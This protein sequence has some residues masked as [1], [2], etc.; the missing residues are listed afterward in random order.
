MEIAGRTAYK[1]DEKGGSVVCFWETTAKNEFQSK[2]QG[3]PIFDLVIMGE[4]R[5]PGAKMSVFDFEIER[6]ITDGPIKQRVNERS[7]LWVDVL[8]IQLDAWRKQKTDQTLSGTPLESWPRLGV[9]EI[10]SLR[11][12]GI[13]S[14][15]QLSEVPDS[16]LEVLGMNGRVLRDQAKAHIELAKNNAPMEALVAKNNE[17]ELALA[18]LKEQFEALSANLPEEEKRG[19]GRPRKAA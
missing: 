8:Q 9:T 17:L 13:F 3:R 6:H 18:N 4:I 11:A 16:R 12:S 14:I 7:E 19:P 5:S 1:L 10:A 2:S 15:E